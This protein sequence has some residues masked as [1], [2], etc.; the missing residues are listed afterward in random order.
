MKNNIYY[1]EGGRH[2]VK[3]KIRRII[4]VL[5]DDTA[6]I[7]TKHDNSIVVDACNQT[8]DKVKEIATRFFKQ[9]YKLN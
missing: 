6:I 8:P 3:N 1:I 4:T 9:A 5:K 2:A 7:I